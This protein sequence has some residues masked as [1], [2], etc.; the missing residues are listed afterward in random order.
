MVMGSVMGSWLTPVRQSNTRA[1]TLFSFSLTSHN[2]QLPP[3]N[4]GCQVQ[5]SA[6]VS[7]GTVL[8]MVH[9]A[10]AVLRGRVSQDRPTLLARVLRA[11]T[12]V[13]VVVT[14]ALGIWWVAAGVGV[15]VVVVLVQG[16]LL[17]GGAA[18][19]LCSHIFPRARVYCCDGSQELAT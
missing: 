8:G 7:A 10:A 5:Q 6:A 15:G 14:R 16:L 4:S 2:Q 19:L 3:N 18:H 11:T 17:L 13:V 1:R 12:P 9:W